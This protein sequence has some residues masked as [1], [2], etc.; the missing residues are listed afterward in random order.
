V[1]LWQG[2]RG[3]ESGLGAGLGKPR[4]DQSLEVDDDVLLL[5]VEGLNEICASQVSSGEQ[6]G[7]PL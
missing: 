4:K 7:Y 3:S 1:Q 5:L 6:D 2:A